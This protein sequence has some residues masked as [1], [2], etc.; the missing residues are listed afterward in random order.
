M[1]PGSCL[2][3][4]RSAPRPGRAGEALITLPGNPVSTFV[5]L[6]LFV[7]PAVRALRGLGPEKPSRAVLAAP[8]RSP[9]AKRSCICGVLDL[10]HGAVTPAPAQSTFQLTTLARSNALIIVPGQVTA[11]SEGDA[12][13][14][15]GLQPRVARGAVIRDA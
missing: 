6:R 3:S 8:L 14:V 12:V 15:L 4:A 1:S 5:S 7:L 9:A 10:G 13:E 11:L 2:S